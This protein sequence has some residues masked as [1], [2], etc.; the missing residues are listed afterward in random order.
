MSAHLP[1][2]TGSDCVMRSLV[3]RRVVQKSKILNQDRALLG[4]Q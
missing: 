3:V 2:I 1:G 4:R